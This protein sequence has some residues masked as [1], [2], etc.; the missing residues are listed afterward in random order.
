MSQGKVFAR[1]QGVL[2]RS[3]CLSKSRRK[4]QTLLLLML[5]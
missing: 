5:T 1:A 4:L 2:K 3:C